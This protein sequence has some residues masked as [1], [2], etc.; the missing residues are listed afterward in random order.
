MSLINVCINGDIEECE[1]IAVEYDRLTY[2]NCQ[3]YYEAFNAAI[4]H[5]HDKIADMLIKRLTN[6]DLVCLL[7][8][9]ISLGAHACVLWALQKKAERFAQLG[10]QDRVKLL[11][12]ANLHQHS[13]IAIALI[14]MLNWSVQDIANLS[15]SNALYHSVSAPKQLKVLEL[16]LKRLK[17]CPSEYSLCTAANSGNLKAV[18]LLLECGQNINADAR[19]KALIA[20]AGGGHINIVKYLLLDKGA[21]CNAIH[22]TPYGRYSC[23]GTALMVAACK[24][25]TDIVDMLIKHG[26][27]K[28]KELSEFDQL[29]SAV[30]G[31]QLEI[32]EKFVSLG[33]NPLAENDKTPTSTF[34]LLMVATNFN[35]PELVS[36]FLNKGV[37]PA[38]KNRDG[39]TVYDTATRRKLSKIQQILSGTIERP[40]PS[41]TEPQT[42]LFK[43]PKSRAYRPP[44]H[45]STARTRLS[46]S[47]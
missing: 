22:N 36:Y 45:P 29:S 16:L 32:V 44:R 28:V 15:R 47:E 27:T 18:E 8:R 10:S 21:N 24:G 26:A 20:A 40:N 39:E 38:A 37:N 5:G 23:N 19:D 2:K 12:T 34:T 33:L 1:K 6:D 41:A 14:T 31:G 7:D 17:L 11:D 13:D 46:V 35:Y 9:F 3:Q 43:S 42:D 30:T 25:H 4:T